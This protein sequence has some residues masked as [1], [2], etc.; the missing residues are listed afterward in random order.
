[1]ARIRRQRGTKQ[2]YFVTMRTQRGLPFNCSEVMN[3]MLLSKLA[4]AQAVHP[5]VLGDVVFMGNHVHFTMEVVDPRDMVRFIRHFKT[6]SALAI[7]EMMGLSDCKCSVWEEGYHTYM[8]P[9][10]GSYMACLVYLHSNPIKANL[11]RKAKEYPGISTFK[12]LERAEGRFSVEVPR[13]R[14]G[15]FTKMSKQMSSEDYGMYYSVMLGRT[16]IKENQS[17]SF[18]PERIYRRVLENERTA[19]ESV[20]SGKDKEKLSSREELSYEEFSQLV[21]K[22]VRRRERIHER[23]RRMFNRG[24]VGAEE[25]R[26]RSIYTEYEGKRRRSRRKKVRFIL[27]RCARVRVWAIEREKSLNEM[28]DEVKE[29]KKGGDKEVMYPYGYFEPGGEM[30]IYLVPDYYWKWVDTAD[31]G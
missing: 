10:L 29:K 22:Y 17:V 1:M 23:I 4:R 6:E 20:G 5:V 26:T 30:K 13:F 28:Y 12:E 8:L 7:N 25:L 16:N 9:C 31:P 18:N 27:S 14:R 11:V 15:V 21:V 3:T 2:V 24:V 19:I